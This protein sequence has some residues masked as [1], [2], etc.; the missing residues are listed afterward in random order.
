[1]NDPLAELKARMDDL[2]AALR[3]LLDE[4]EAPLLPDLETQHQERLRRLR[5]RAK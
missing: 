5:R 4:D 3:T 1:V 2:E